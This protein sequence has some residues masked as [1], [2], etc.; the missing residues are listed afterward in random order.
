MPWVLGVIFTLLG[1]AFLAWGGS[2]VRRQAG[3]ARSWRRDRATVVGYEWHGPHDRSVQHWVMERTD[4]LGRTHR[5][6]SELGVSGGT[7][8]R[9]PFDV[10]VLVDPADEARYV[11]AGGCRS[12]WGGIFLAVVGGVFLVAGVVILG[13]QVMG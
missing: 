10:D 2:S 3:R 5:A 6:V 11:L 8:R 9:F 7:L 1:G 12:G 13:W 4:P